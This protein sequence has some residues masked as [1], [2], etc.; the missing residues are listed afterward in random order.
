MSD[1]A[2]HIKSPGDL[3]VGKAPGRTHIGA[4]CE[5]WRGV[6]LNVF[7][8]NL[9]SEITRAVQVDNT[10]RI[11]TVVG[12]LSRTARFSPAQW[13]GGKHIRVYYQSDKYT[14][15]EMCNDDGESR[16]TPG[17]RIAQE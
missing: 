7:W 4:L 15:L 5:T 12:P 2:A 11:S 3:N 14:V 6:R 8:M 10:W 17:G 13:A 9:A 16:W 1:V